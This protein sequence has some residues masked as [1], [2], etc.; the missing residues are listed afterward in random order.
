MGEQPFTW[1]VGKSNRGHLVNTAV[2]LLH[3]IFISLDSAT[4]TL[5]TG[6]GGVSK[7]R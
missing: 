4:N 5:N 6:G 3:G 2:T 7:K 1:P